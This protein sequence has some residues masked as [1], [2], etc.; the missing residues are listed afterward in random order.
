MK[1]SGFAVTVFFIKDRRGYDE[2]ARLLAPHN[3]HVF[4]IESERDLHELNPA[5]IGQ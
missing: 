4:H 1:Y 2:A 3:I 5:R